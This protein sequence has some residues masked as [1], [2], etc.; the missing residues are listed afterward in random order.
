[1]PNVVRVKWAGGYVEV[2]DNG[3]GPRRTIPF[4]GGNARTRDQAI[5]I[6][7]ATLAEFGTRPIRSVTA[8]VGDT[9]TW[10]DVGDAVETFAQDGTTTETSRL[11]SR[12]VSINENGFAVLEPTLSHKQDQ[13]FIRNQLALKKLTV[14]ASNQ[15]NAGGPLLQ[16]EQNVLSG[17][18]SES[19]TITWSSDTIK[20]GMSPLQKLN[21]PIVFTR[22]QVLIANRSETATTSPALS[23]PLVL[24]IKINGTLVYLVT[25][26]ANVF[27]WNVLGGGYYPSGTTVQVGIYNLGSNS[28]LDRNKRNLTI[29]WMGVAASFIRE[30]K[31]TPELR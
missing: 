28:L 24:T 6:A 27:E 5:Q 25:F 2:S 18:V 31:V 11:V 26:P 10:P 7:T 9:P 19:P 23:Y 1:M 4:D 29:N 17:Q 16:P 20:L 15:T 12:R 21:E 14:N 3:G 8:Q 22:F 13:L 30:N